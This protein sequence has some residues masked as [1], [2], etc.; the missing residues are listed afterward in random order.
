MTWHASREQPARGSAHTNALG[1]DCSPRLAVSFSEA[2][3]AEIGRHA[4]R[5]NS[6][7]SSVV[8]YAVRRLLYKWRDYK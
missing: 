1:H 8:R 7:A 4:A 6:T 3:L 2:D 5:L